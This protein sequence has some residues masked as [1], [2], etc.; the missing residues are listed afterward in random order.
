MHLCRK[1]VVYFI[2]EQITALFA[3]GNEL[4]YCIIFL[5]KTYCC[6]NSS[7]IGPIS[8]ASPDVI[9]A[10]FTRKDTGRLARRR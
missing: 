10:V 8:R 6:T 2:V 4:A 3:Y 9:G 7:A 5:F 1:R